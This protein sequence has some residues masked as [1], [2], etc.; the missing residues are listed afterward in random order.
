MPQRDRWDID[1]PFFVEITVEAA[2]IDRLN[3]VNNS[4]YMRYM[5]HAAWQ[6]TLALGLDWQRYTELD[7]ACVVRRHEVDYLAAAVLGDRLQVATWIAENDGRLAMWRCFQI[8]HAD[9]GRTIFRGRTQYV[10][11]TLSTGRPRRMPEA[12]VAAY[13]P[14]GDG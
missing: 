12:F 1:V 6:H 7:A 5:E 3:H 11:V 8:R 13:R 9:T 2:D 10:T 14:A 4:V